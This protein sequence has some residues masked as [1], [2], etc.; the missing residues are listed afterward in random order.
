VPE[1]GPALQEILR[2][3]N[4][5]LEATEVEVTPPTGVAVPMEADDVLA[6]VKG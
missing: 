5:T 2:A 3:E 6:R 1:R 4:V